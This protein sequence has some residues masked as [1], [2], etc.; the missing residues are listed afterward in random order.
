MRGSAAFRMA[1]HATTQA[2]SSMLN[3]H[4]RGRRMGLKVMAQAAQA[5]RAALPGGVEQAFPAGG[6]IE[7]SGPV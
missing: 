2:D 1:V 5:V 4:V 3:G 6:L 7:L